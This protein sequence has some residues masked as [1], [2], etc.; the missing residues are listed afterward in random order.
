MKIQFIPRLVKLL[1]ISLATL[2]ISATPAS[3]VGYV[4]AADS[5]Q[6]CAP[7]S[8]LTFT[9][10][11]IHSPISSG[12]ASANPAATRFN[13]AFRSDANTSGKYLTVHFFDVT[14][15]MHL[16]PVI[17][18]PNASTGCAASGATGKNCI[19]KA[20]SLGSASFSITIM[21]SSIG[22]SF[23]Y[24]IM[25]PAGFASSAVNV[26]FTKTGSNSQPAGTCT[27]DR[28]K[29]CTPISNVGMTLENKNVKVTYAV[30]G[31]GTA[32]IG[33]SSSLINFIYSSNTEYAYKW[34]F[35]K[36]LNISSGITI[37]LDSGDPTLSTTC[38]AQD[39][40]FNGCRIRLDANGSASFMVTVAGNQI[41]KNFQYEISGPNYD[42][43]TVTVRF[44]ASPVFSANGGSL[45]SA[46]VTGAKSMVKILVLS[47]KGQKVSV[48]IGSG[49]KIAFVPESNFE[50]YYFPRTKGSVKVVVTIGT[51]KITKT[52]KIT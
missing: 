11:G 1:V 48:V 47:S 21:N 30:D 24:Q 28:M 31:T 5:S 4:C 29:V 19:I 51:T 23:S 25:G 2:G 40:N 6:I 32:T 12:L 9:T 36:F 33:T 18:D 37:S 50:S 20:N 52:I 26:M 16:L 35:I 17:G 7:I 39:A 22:K 10:N 46:T 15:G 14:S 13:F 34:A 27:A 45:G 44:A 49:P 42:S 3:A 41:G 38:E 8:A 43:K